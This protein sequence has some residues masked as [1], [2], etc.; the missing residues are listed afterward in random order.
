MIY[1]DSIE[2][3]KSLLSLDKQLTLIFGT[4]LCSDCLTVRSEHRTD[5]NSVF[6]D[7]LS[8]GPFFDEPMKEIFDLSHDLPNV[9]EWPSLLQTNQENIFKNYM[10]NWK[11]DVK[12]N[13]NLSER[14]K[15]NSILQPIKNIKR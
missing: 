6:I 1:V 12:Y 11:M 7:V 13:G 5:A 10:K 14:R 9:V 15:F 2:F 3:F 4:E 8:L